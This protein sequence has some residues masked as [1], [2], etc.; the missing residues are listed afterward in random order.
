MSAYVVDRNHIQ[1]LVKAAEA[2]ARRDRSNFSWF[3]QGE[4][5]NMNDT[6]E[7]I[8]AGNMLW[9][10][11]IK[12]INARYPDTV[13]NFDNMPGPVDE[14]F[15]FS[16]K[17]IEVCF[18]AFKPAQVLKSCHCLDYQSCE[19]DGWEASEARAFLQAL[20]SNAMRHV[21][22]YEDAE[23]GAPEPEKGVIS[24]NSLARKPRR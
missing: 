11:N 2:M 3:W 24:L 4:W 9:Q 23:W 18:E 21:P 19:H 5:H 15:T 12:S 16:E 20:E 10:E 1:Y 8:R 13:G 6:T 22:G 7:M 14:N 17:D